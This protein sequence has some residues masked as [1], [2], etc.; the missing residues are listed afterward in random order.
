MATPIIKSIHIEK[1][2]A[3]Q[4]VHFE[5]TSNVVAIAGQN[6]TM[7]TTLLGMLSQPFSLRRKGPLKDSKTLDGKPYGVNMEGI[8]KFSPQYDQSGEHIF[9]LYLDEDVCERDHF[10]CKSISAKGRRNNIRFWNAE[11]QRKRNTGFIQL[12]VIFLSLKRLLPIGESSSTSCQ[13]Q[14]NQKEETQFKKFHNEILTISDNIKDV[15]Y[16]LGRQ[17][18]TLAGN[19]DY[20]DS[21]AVSA[22]QDDIGK[23]IMSLFS[24]ARLKEEHQ[25]DYKGGILCIDEIESTLFPSAQIE[26]LKI[27]KHEANELNLQI[28][29]TT[30]S[31]TI[32]EFLTSTNKEKK[33]YGQILFLVNR[34]HEVQ[35]KDFDYKHM[36]SNLKI[37]PTSF[38]NEQMIKVYTEDPEAQL[39]VQYLLE[40]YNN[41]LSYQDCSL[42]CDAYLELIRNNFSEFRNNIVILDGDAG[43]NFKKNATKEKFMECWSYIIKL[44][45]DNQSPE[46]LFYRFLHSLKQADPF[47][48]DDGCTYQW[49]FKD[50]SEEPTD[51]NSIK[52]WFNS[53]KEFWGENCHDLFKY[54]EDFSPENKELADK[55]REEFRKR[56]QK[57]T[58]KILK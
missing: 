31:Q 14:L 41:L 33:E 54:W 46:S 25:Q 28:F 48:N 32:L 40:P 9:T 38:I 17:K 22:G 16:I 36:V 39:F 26:L 29:F 8:F 21:I 4:D 2:R 35:K 53:R 55:F 6:G 42:G 52:T 30:H 49:C 12:P 50:Y 18:S 51:R 45:A 11:G 44:P 58:G 56:Y 1:F 20:Y 47:W 43:Y 27:L 34:D 15:N 3:F 5:F 37:I 13:S 23:I 10:T 24:F 57:L 7:K 19:T